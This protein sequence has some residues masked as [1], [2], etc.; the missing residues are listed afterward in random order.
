MV[1]S[2]DRKPAKRKYISVQNKSVRVKYERI[3]PIASG[4]QNPVAVDEANGS[5]PKAI[6]ATESIALN[7]EHVEK[8]YEEPVFFSDTLDETEVSY[9]EKKRKRLENWAAITDELVQVGTAVL[10]TPPHSQC[11][12]CMQSLDQVC[13]CMDCG[14]SAVYCRECNDICHSLSHLHKFEMFKIG[15]FVCVDTD[16]P[17]WRRPDNHEPLTPLGTYAIILKKYYHLSQSSLGVV[18]PLVKEDIRKKISGWTSCCSKTWETAK[19]VNTAVQHHLKEYNLLEGS[20]MPYPDKLDL[21]SLKSLEVPASVPEELQRLLINLYETKDR[22]EE[23][24]ELIACDMRSTNCFLYETTGSKSDVHRAVLLL[25]GLN[26]ERCILHQRN[27]SSN[28]SI[29]N[30]VPLHFHKKLQLD[31]PIVEQEISGSI[32]GNLVSDEYLLEQSDVEGSESM[33]SYPSS[34]EADDIEMGT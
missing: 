6:S 15:T 14:T 18:D 33:D 29:V 12:R 3:S 1:F 23:E 25:E 22:C 28:V 21:D 2:W 30:E 7:S 13:R 17:V 9:R 10:F 20:K 27:M 8:Q 16:T 31:L 11:I 4:E 24:I 34:D 5:L 32:L 19:K 26:T